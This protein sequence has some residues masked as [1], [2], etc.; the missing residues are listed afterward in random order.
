MPKS[1]LPKQTL[2]SWLMAANKDA[3]FDREEVLSN[4]IYYPGS[5]MDGHVL[6]SYAGVSH[7]FIYADPGVDKN[8]LLKGLRKIAGYDLVF[9]KEISMADLSPKP[10]LEHIARP[11]DFYPRPKNLNQFLEAEKKAYTDLVWDNKKFTPYAIWA[12]LERRQSAN[13]THGPKRLSITFITGEG[14]ATYAAIYNSNLVVPL[15]IVI[16]GA[17]IGFGRN[18]TFFEQKNGPFER[19]VMSNI[20][21]IPK[22]IFA[23]N[24]YNP[25]EPDHWFAKNEKVDFYWDKYT[26][27]INDPGYLNVWTVTNLSR[28]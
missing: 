6:R 21:G 11:T 26:T 5:C 23:W 22:Y 14:V 7:S 17:D 3:E 28:T 8:D 12:V 27:K 20:A 25:I 19:V 16:C 13:D 9:A 18:W 2:P 10:N 4:S 15:A 24:R 1:K